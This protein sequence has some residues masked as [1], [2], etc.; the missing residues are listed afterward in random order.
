[1]L[2]L[3]RGHDDR[4]DAELAEG[5][6]RLEALALPLAAPDAQDERDSSAIVKGPAVSAI[7]RRVVSGE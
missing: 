5:E 2:E 1:V 6:L 3:A 4:L 7:F